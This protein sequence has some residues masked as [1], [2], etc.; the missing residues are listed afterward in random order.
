MC[1][2]LMWLGCG[3]KCGLE[4]VC[5]IVVRMCVWDEVCLMWPGGVLLD[6]CVLRWFGCGC[7]YCGLVVVRVLWFGCVLSVAF[8]CNVA[9]MWCV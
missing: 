2:C 6:V 3:F 9:W 1:V 5:V 4:V 8:V 7:V